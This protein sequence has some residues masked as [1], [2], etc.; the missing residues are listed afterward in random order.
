MTIAFKVGHTCATRTICDH[1]CIVSFMILAR[2]AKT[3]I[4]CISQ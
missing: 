3:P 2:T 4:R 1:N